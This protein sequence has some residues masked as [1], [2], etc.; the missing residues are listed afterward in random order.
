LTVAARALL[1]VTGSELVRGDR[2]DA[3]GPFLAAELSRRGVEP[4]RIMVVGDRPE[5]LLAALE[6]GLQ[7]DVLVTSGGLGPTHDDRTVETLANATGR[8]LVVDKGLEREIEGISRGFADRLGRP[9]AGFSAGVTKQASLPEG[10]ISLG[11][12]GTAPALLL[13]HEACVVVVLPG[14]PA[15]LRRLWPLALE[16][17]A[18]KA[19]LARAAP[20]EHRV[21]RLF[22]P[23]ES[24][25]ARALDESGGERDE[26]EVTVCARDLEIHVD[27]F[28]APKNATGAQRVEEALT[29]AFGGQLFAVDDERAIAA[30]V[31]EAARDSG[32]VIVTAESSTGGLIAAELTDVPG[33][34]ESYLGGVVA[35]SDDLKRQELD[36]PER[37][38]REYGAVS[39]ETAAAMAEGARARFG[40][41]VAVAVTGIAGPGGG[42]TEKP[43]GLVFI[44]VASRDGTKVRRFELP[45]DRESVR[46]RT[47]ALALHMLRRVLTRT[48]TDPRESGR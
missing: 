5:E 32:E 15:E 24:A 35:Y 28:Y 21:L 27:L 31:L 17:P 42:S 12:A 3:N 43:V 8:Q 45:G 1:V 2:L 44:S 23:S 29:A 14:P 39:V 9:Y 22:G 34:S 46:A 11:L 41:G 13:E 30:L 25:V 18:M 33:S 40:A 47:T 36:V 10:A 20:R 16:H 6:E 19:V 38:L 26:L 37:V 7:A 48:D 4:G